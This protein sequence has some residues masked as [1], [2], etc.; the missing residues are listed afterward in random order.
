MGR[1]VRWLLIV[2]VAA[3]TRAEL[4]RE[5]SITLLPPDIC[6]RSRDPEESLIT[7]YNIL[8]YNSFG[9]L[10]YKAYIPRREYSGGSPSIK[11]RL[12]RESP[13]TVLAAAN[14]G[15]GLNF[16]SLE[17]ARAYRFHMAYPDEFEAGI[18]MAACTSI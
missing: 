17:E 5:V 11:A 1:G 9:M 6:T 7:D 2:V 8:V 15:Y 4:P 3:C 12:L 10:E 16:N 18:P 13:Y 14:L